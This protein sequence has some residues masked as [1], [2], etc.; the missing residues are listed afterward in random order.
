MEF[1]NNYE[2]R[3]KT[4]IKDSIKKLKTLIFT[5]VIDTSINGFVSKEPV[6][7]KDRLNYKY[8]PFKIGKPWTSELFNCAW[9][10]LKTSIPNYKKENKYYLVLDYNSELLLFDNKGVPLKGFTPGSSVFD[11]ALGEPGKDNYLINSLLDKDILDCY[12]E[13]GANDLFGFK[14]NDFII[15]E[16]Y[17][18]LKNEE[19][20][21]LYYDLEFL[22]S[23]VDTLPS[24]ALNSSNEFKAL[25]EI[26]HLIT[27]ENPN[28]VEIALNITKEFFK[29]DN[30]S[31]FPLYVVGH[32][33]MDL[34]W[35]WPVRETKRKIAR[36]IANVVYLIEKNPSF[37]FGISQMQQLAWLKELYPELFKKV[38]HYVKLGNIEIQGGMWVESDSNLPGEE[39]LIRQFLHGVEFIKKEF[40]IK[41][42]NCWL[43][44]CFG[45]NG[46]MPQII[47]SC[48]IDNFMTIKI[49]WNLVN[50]FPYKTFIW[51]G[52]DTSKVVV[53]MPPEAT[54]NSP[55]NCNSIKKSVE[56][57]P[58][59]KIAPMAL[60]VYGIG[61]GGGGPGD[62]HVSRIEHARKFN[63]LP[64][65]PIY[66]S[67]SKFFDELNKYYDKLP[68]WKGE[69]YLENHQ[70]CYSSA[71]RI[72]H[73]N[74]LLE[75]QLRSLEIYFALKNNI[76]KY[77]NF[78]KYWEEV[79]LYQFHDILPGSSIMRVYEEA[80]KRYELM[81]TEL[82]NLTNTNESY[83]FN[84]N[85]RSANFI[86]FNPSKNEITSYSIQ[87]L[88][89]NK[90]QKEKGKK[91]DSLK[92]FKTNNLEIAI[93]SQSGFIESIKYFDKELLINNEGNKLSVYKDFGNGWDIPDH[94]RSQVPLT[95]KL[96]KQTIFE[97]SKYYLI[98]NNFTFLNSKLEESIIID[99]QRDLVYFYHNLDF[100]DMHYMLRTSFNIDIDTPDVYCDIQ[101]G[102]LKRSRLNDT[103][104]NWAQYE[105]AAQKWVLVKDDKRAIGLI[106]KTKNGFYAKDNILDITLSRTSDYPGKTLGIEKSSYSYVLA[107]LES[108]HS[109]EE[110]DWLANEYNTFYPEVNQSDNLNLITID[111]K[112]IYLSALKKAISDEAYIIRLSNPTETSQNFTL[113]ISFDYEEITE[114]NSVEEN[115][116]ELN[117]LNLVLKPFSFMSIK[118][119]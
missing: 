45:F 67:A 59:A 83:R 41:V 3:V 86:D 22:L 38:K 98:K 49:A 19:I 5:K 21:K 97:F 60:S 40:D 62:E 78:N 27:Y 82:K 110:L 77:P 44:D 7:Y 20:E 76:K 103:R 61:D 28:F 70:G 10:N 109:L 9:F 11:R 111:N 84:P 15:K 100:K 55:I 50:L 106:T 81:H 33:H 4:Q 18:G 90:G 53:H 114:V 63:S 68:H 23:Y 29:N 35:L 34:A 108:K 51:E 73:Y 14:Q 16:S 1:N 101:F 17:I 42:N 113:E 65:K 46:N 12:I 87:A 32:S 31:N 24:E 56:N 104:I 47:K 112:N 102:H 54:Y 52:I 96:E 26:S 95:P 66:S 36:N 93:S 2:L 89:T 37:V 117:N 105:I 72:K 85:L 75:E 74:R 30:L 91:I 92:L 94:Y 119:K 107:P 99:K 115:I 48:G 6:L 57:Y 118:I 79:L 80:I 43:P 8:T 88:S 116:K 64:A 13:A 69:L 39:A 71:P 25:V 58:E